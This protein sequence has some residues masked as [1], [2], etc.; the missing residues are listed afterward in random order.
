M[1][2]AAKKINM[3]IRQ[4]YNIILGAFN[5]PLRESLQNSVDN[6]FYLLS[7]FIHCENMDDRR[8]LDDKVIGH[9][10]I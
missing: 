3:I 6:N 8:Y 2:K 1:N 4:S 9:N 10:K 5:S 7:H